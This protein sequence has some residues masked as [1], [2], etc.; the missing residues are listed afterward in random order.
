MF[1]QIDGALVGL[2]VRGDE[3]AI[4]IK[5]DGTEART[6]F[7]IKAISIVA[8]S[9]ILQSLQETE[10]REAERAAQRAGHTA[11]AGTCR[12]GTK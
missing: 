2:H 8:D 11:A 12:P 6:N 9:L 5:D 7:A 4:T 1:S 10:L 3:T